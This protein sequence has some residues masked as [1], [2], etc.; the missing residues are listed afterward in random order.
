ML[1][2]QPKGPLDIPPVDTNK[3]SIDL[4]VPPDDS[5]QPLF[6]SMTS[7][8]CLHQLQSSPIKFIKSTVFQKSTNSQ[9]DFLFSLE[10]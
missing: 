6:V 1:F 4:D 2:W 10:G 7:W 3:R 9:I 5:G 8:R